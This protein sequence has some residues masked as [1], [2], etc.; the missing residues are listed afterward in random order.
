MDKYGTDAPHR[1]ALVVYPGA[2]HSFDAN[3]PER[4]YFGHQLVHDP[5]AT[6][7]AVEGTPTDNQPE[8]TTPLGALRTI[9][10]RLD[11][12]L[13][14]LEALRLPKFLRI[15]VFVWPFLLLAAFFDLDSNRSA[16]S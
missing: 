2:R 10:T 11:S 13:I 6:A 8:D 14:A 7:D 12:D 16:R 9:C 15:D 1:P 4:V 5:K 3:E